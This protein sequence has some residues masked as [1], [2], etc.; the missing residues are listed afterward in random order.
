MSFFEEVEDGVQKFLNNLQ[1]IDRP[2]SYFPVLDGITN[3]GK[4]LEL[5]FSCYVVKIKYMLGLWDKIEEDKKKDWTKFLN[6]FQKEESNFPKYSYIDNAYLSNARKTKLDESIK[7]I[8]KQIFSNLNIKKYD[9]KK[10]RIFNSVKAETKQAISTLFQVGRANDLPYVDFPN[11]ELEIN[12]YLTSLDWSFPW[13]A[14]AQYS[15]LCVFNSTQKNENNNFEILRKFSEKIVNKAN[16]F[17]YLGEK[18]QDYELVNG[19]MKVISGFNWINQEIHYKEKLIDNCL[20]IK[21]TNYGCDLVDIVYVLHQCALT[22]N[23]KRKEINLYMENLIPLI[24]KHYFEDMG[25][26]SYY[27]NKSQT[28]YY[29]VNFSNGTKTP[30]IHGTILLVWALSMIRSLVEENSH[31]KVLKP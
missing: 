24:R 3:E 25:G 8:G 22:T 10:V 30:D 11:N 29:G 14:G 26:F 9:S 17:Y 7:D 5:G 27:V 28:S 16:G 21:P 31:W 13:N 4:E 19:A 12:N 2:F 6:S 20:K 1:K 15:A 23:Y 18:P